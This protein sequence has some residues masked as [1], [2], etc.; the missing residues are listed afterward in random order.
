MKRSKVTFD[1]SALSISVSKMVVWTLEMRYSLHVF[2]HQ[3]QIT[4]WKKFTKR[5]CITSQSLSKVADD[6]G[7]LPGSYLCD[8]LGCFGDETCGS[9]ICFR[10][11]EC[12]T[13]T[14]P[15]G[16]CSVI[17]TLSQQGSK[18]AQTHND[19]RRFTDMTPKIRLNRSSAGI[20]NH[21]HW[22]KF[23]KFCQMW[24]LCSL[25]TQISTVG[26]LPTSSAPFVWNN[27]TKTPGFM[28][29]LMMTEAPR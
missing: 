16:S 2:K 10:N 13:K 17:A 1:G 12:Q 19:R 14:A 29:K 23:H 3:Q 25:A 27:L 6:M 11:V 20:Q 18:T 7:I 15:R 4:M 26:N 22:K 5:L 24:R 21:P 8:L 28:A 9:K